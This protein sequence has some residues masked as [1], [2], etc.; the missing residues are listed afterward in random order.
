MTV[1]TGSGSTFASAQTLRLELTGTATEGSDYTIDAT[2]LILPAGTGR[3]PSTVTTTVRALDDPFDDN[4]ETVALSATRDGVEF[5]SRAVAIAD[6]DIGSTRVDL[7][8]NPA[9]VREDAGA[10]TV[11]VTATLDGAARA[12]ATD[13]AVTVGAS[14]DSAVEGTDYAT[15]ADLALTIDAGK[16]T[17]E[18]TF[19]LAPTNNDSVEGAKTITVDGSV[20]GLAVRSVDLTLNDDDVAS[21]NVT[22]T[23]DPLEVRESVRSRT[24]RVTGTLD[25]GARPTPTVVAVTVG[26]GGD[27]ATEGTDYQDVGDLELTIPA[28]RT[29]GTVTFTLRPTND[30]TAEGTE[31]ISVRGNVAG[32][33]V[34]P[35]ELTIA[36]DDTV[37]T[38]L[39]LSLNPSTVSE[40]AAPTEV[41]VTGSLD[42]GARTSDTV[43]TVTVGAFTDTATQGLDYANVSTLRITVPANETTGQTMFTLSPD[44]DAIAEGAETI[45]VTGRT[46]GLNVEPAVLT[47]SDNDAAS[48]IVTLSVA[49]ASVSEDVPEDVTVTAALD[50]GARAEDTAVRLTVGAAGDTAVPGTDYE[51]VSERTLTILSGETG[52]TATFLLEPLDNDSA[53]GARTLSVTGSTTVAE[54]RIEPATGAKVAL[55]DDDSPALLVTPDT[56]TV[57]EAESDTYAVELQTRPTPTSR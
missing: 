37:S 43:V 23:L 56:L 14:G 11:R 36:D 55:E 29:D 38:R 31:T 20:P 47:L 27:S 52:G 28:N 42:A 53:D 44:N 41:V 21:T 24:V 9:Q 57:V 17:A 19:R 18:T 3:D 1:S 13:V 33:T 46:N 16:T 2:S 40:A 51:P 49:P 25:G 35:A 7:A 8:V 50:A 10:T 12:E 4:A 39:D 45:S 54:L 32:L 15:V 48:R 6:D 26:S 34:T 22:L 5:A 30:R